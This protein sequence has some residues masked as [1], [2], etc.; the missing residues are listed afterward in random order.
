M[1]REEEEGEESVGGVLGG[2]DLGAFCCCL[3]DLGVLELGCGRGRRG[4]SEMAQRLERG[5]YGS[6][7]SLFFISPL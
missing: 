2:R 3:F 1:E 6:G 5:Y 7:P 4:R